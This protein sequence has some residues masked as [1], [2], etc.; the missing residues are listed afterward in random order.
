[1]QK[2]AIH[3]QGLLNR[4]T[5][6][7]GIDSR[8]TGH[9]R[10]GATGSEIAR[11]TLELKAFKQSTAGGLQIFVFNQ[12]VGIEEAINYIFR[13]EFDFKNRPKKNLKKQAFHDMIIGLWKNNYIKVPYPGKELFIYE[14]INK[15]LPY[16]R[17]KI[18]KKVEEKLP[19]PSLG[20]ETAKTQPKTKSQPREEGTSFFLYYPTK[21]GAERYN[22]NP[23]EGRYQRTDQYKDLSHLVK[24]AKEFAKAEGRISR[25]GILAHGLQVP[26]QGSSQFGSDS[27]TYENIDNYRDAIRP[28]S[29]C[30]TKD[31]IV[32]LVGCNAGG[33]AQGSIFLKAW[34]VYLPGREVVGFSV[35]TA[36]SKEAVG[37][38]NMSTVVITTARKTEH[39]KEYEPLKKYKGMPADEKNPLAKIALDGAI[40]EWPANEKE[41]IEQL[42]REEWR[43]RNDL[44]SRKLKE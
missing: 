20:K 41:N 37:G 29:E 14:D 6:N 42:I 32:L 10:S 44:E 23:R 30:L 15:L 1:M 34:S 21:K 26:G 2:P 16:L 40:K 7:R 25:L 18:K 43:I 33:G 12:Q 3:E 35:M 11:G 27:I 39:G 9:G 24:L 8:G 4:G 19:P 31:A 13:I 38:G 28:L 17:N 5:L 36:P 22:R